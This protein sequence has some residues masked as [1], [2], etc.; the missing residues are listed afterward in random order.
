MKTFVSLDLN[1]MVKLILVRCVHM[2]VMIVTMKVNVLLAIQ[3]ILEFSTT[4][5]SVANL[6]LDTTKILLK[7]V[8]GVLLAVTIANQL[9]YV[10]TVLKDI[11]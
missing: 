11:I 9:Q 5:R 4:K 3:Q 10:I 8:L 6:F 1:K 7:F 2:I